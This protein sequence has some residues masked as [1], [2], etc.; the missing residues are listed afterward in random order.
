MTS[1][2]TISES[3]LKIII[4]RQGKNGHVTH[5]H[6]HKKK[7]HNIGELFATGRLRKTSRSSSQA[8]TI[9]LERFVHTKN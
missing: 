7:E 9:D 8:V 4:W 2:L 6:T 1:H 3:E 5:T